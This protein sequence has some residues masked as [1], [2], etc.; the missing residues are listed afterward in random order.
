[1]SLAIAVVLQ[2]FGATTASSTWTWLHLATHLP[3]VLIVSQP[4]KGGVPKPTFG[5]PF[6]EPDMYPKFECSLSLPPSSEISENEHVNGHHPTDVSKRDVQMGT[7]HYGAQ[8][9]RVALLGRSRFRPMTSKSS[10]EAEMVLWSTH[11]VPDRQGAPGDCLSRG[12]RLLAF[13]AQTIT[14]AGPGEIVHVPCAHPVA[15]CSERVLGRR[16][17]SS[18]AKF[19]GGKRI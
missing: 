5:R 9:G 7:V 6:H 4:Q 11:A 13:W 10:V 17:L 18:V 1:M 16:R 19:D 3:S 8:R 14:R 15:R 12:H 2:A